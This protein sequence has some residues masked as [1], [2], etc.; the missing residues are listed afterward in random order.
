MSETISQR[1][2]GKTDIDITPIGLG[3]WQFSGGRG[4]VGGFW[5]EV[6]QATVNAIV[7]ASLDG[8]INWFDTAEIYGRGQSEEALA[9]ALDAAGKKPG[10][11]VVATKWWPTARWAES[12]RSTIDERL[13]F[14]SPFPIDLHQVHQPFAFSSVESQMKAMSDLV[15]ARRIRA[16]GV[17]NFSAKRMRAAHEALAT[18]GVPL[19]SNQMRYSLLD[20]S[21]ERNG[22]LAT[23]KQLGIT[24][25]AYSPLAQGILSGKFHAD[26]ALIA[27]SGVRRFTRDFRN[28]GLA[29]SR[30]LIDELA[31][32]ATAHSATSA[33][34]ALAWTI[35]FHGD[36]VVAIPG[37][38]KEKHVTDNVGA[39]TLKLGDLEL[40]RLD[41]LSSSY[42]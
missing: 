36:T 2:L 9:R 28:S 10:D 13:Q 27:A 38:T 7:R 40:K 11:V 15:K 32:I 37:A 5:K 31:R 19:A 34:V 8:G 1:R 30:P 39:M 14:L 12:I 22:V 42:A 33:Q 41:E 24:I 25:I 18:L 21:I 17:S 23:A 16:V 3:C 26:P 35:Q 20:R 6:P 4:L 29:R